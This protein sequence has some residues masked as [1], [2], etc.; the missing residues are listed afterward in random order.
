MAARFSDA[1][2]LDA[3]W[4]TTP[5]Q[6]IRIQQ[7]LRER[8]VREDRL[9]PVRR[10]AA[11]DAHYDPAGDRTWAA[12][13]L[14]A[15]P[16]LDLLQSALLWRPTTFP[17]VPGLLSFREAPAML[18]ALA[19]LRPAPDLLMV[20]GQ[21]IAHPRR[22]GLASHV[23]VLVDRPTVGVAKSRLFGRYAEP[24]PER[25]QWSPLMHR[26]EVIGA[27]LR[28]KERTNPLFISTGHRVS[29]ETALH[30]VEACTTRYRLPEPT[31]LADLLSRA[32]G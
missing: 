4:P 31:R 30:W 19:M 8:V 14:I 24:G 20:D 32:H 11:L 7:E 23:G 9:G 3:D 1:R 6:A 16:G 17:Y 15:W 29:L 27:A 25:G 10:I 21:G 26:K 5:E 2:S 22:I 13:V 18:A 28:N 12:A